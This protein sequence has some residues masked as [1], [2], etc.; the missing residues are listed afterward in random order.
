MKKGLFVLAAAGAFAGTAQAQSQVTVY[1]KM[2]IGLISQSGQSLALGRGDN[3]ALG[4][5]G[6]EDL[7]GGIA[8]VF[9]IETRFQP[10]TGTT[11]TNIAGT[12]V[13]RPLFQGQTR[14]GLTGPFGTIRL[15]R[16]MT[17]VQEN[18]IYDPFE[19]QTVAQ[20]AVSQMAFYSSDPLTVGGSGNRFGNAVFYNSP[21][22]GG[23]QVN[24][25]VATK[26]A[27]GVA[28]DGLSSHPFSLAA[29]YKSGPIS[30]ML[31]YERNAAE[32]KFSIIGASY[33]VGPAKLMATYS[34]QDQSATLATNS[35]TKAWGLG[36][37]IAVGAGK[38][39][40]GYDQSTQDGSKAIQ[41]GGLGYWHYLSKR[42]YLYTDLAR[43]KT[44][45]TGVS[46]NGFDFGI[47]HSF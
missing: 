14:V 9:A 24:V 38:V 35:K 29:T 8:A 31:G 25:T 21:V 22:L 6:R 42:T 36:A 7:G 3:N 27:V 1:G 47:H 39:K 2:D 11:E 4:F 12:S 44:G 23:F 33:Q 18:F 41:K 10:D 17:A 40:V 32:T 16:G 19:T 20:L 28:V 46:V 26:E 13:G 15:G 5:R 30:G 45:D 43:T 34:Q 37:D